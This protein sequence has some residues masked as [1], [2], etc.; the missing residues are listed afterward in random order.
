MF[1]AYR[2]SAT[3]LLLAGFLLSGC[4]LA[5]PDAEGPVSESVNT[6]LRTYPAGSIDSVPKAREAQKAVD[7]EKQALDRRFGVEM[8]A[9]TARFLVNWCYDEVTLR[10]RRDRSALR[11][12]SVEA[13][14]FMRQDKVRQRDAALVDR[15]QKEAVKKGE[16]DAS[17]E[18][19]EKKESQ[20]ITPTDS[21]KSASPESGYVQKVAPGESGPPVLKEGAYTTGTPSQPKE[22]A[23]GSLTPE[24]RAS[25]VRKL[26]KKQLESARKLENVE[27]KKERTQE[28]REKKAEKAAKEEARR[29]NERPIPQ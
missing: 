8:D 23:D 17:R 13:D 18:K 14:R 3:L 5:P 6:I 20:Y 4:V 12:L 19:Y 27:K 24:K 29:A 15:Q 1:P 7:K 10:D 22:G 26:E 25:Q 9:C 11:P 16:R 2:Q 21:Q 28:K